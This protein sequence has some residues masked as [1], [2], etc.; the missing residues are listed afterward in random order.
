MSKFWIN[1]PYATAGNAFSITVTA[2]DPYN[3]TVTDYAG[4]LHFTSSDRQA[5]LPGDYTFTAADAGVHTF[6]DGVTLRSAGGQTLTATDTNTSLTS[7]MTVDVSPAAASTMIVSGFPSPI[8]AGASGSFTV[9]LKD[10]Y[11]NVAW[12]YTGTV[13]LTSSDTKAVLPA[14]Y[15]FTSADAGK[16]SFS[17]TLKTAGTQ[18][19]TATDAVNAS[20]HGTDSG[21]TVKPAA[22]SKFVLSAP[23]S[24]QPGVPFSLTVTVEDAYGN[25]FTGYVGTIHFSSSDSQAHLPANFTFTAG[26]NGVHTFT[27]LVLKKTGNQTIA[28]TDTKNSSITG[29]TVVDVL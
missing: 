9:T 5:S 6:T 21:V 19:I 2:L 23:A 26:N 7:S 1:A 3:N 24:V 27:G 4:T 20:L 8:T 15:T 12:G 22:A 14:N 25:I 11:G 16:H 13:H 17:A 18:S 28:V 10:A 29:K